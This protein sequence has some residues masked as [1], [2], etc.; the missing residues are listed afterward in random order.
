MG[1]QRMSKTTGSML[2]LRSSGG[3]LALLLP[4]RAL[5]TLVALAG[6]LLLAIGASVANGSYPLAMADLFAWMTSGV[7][8]GSRID[9]IIGQFR[10]PRA[11]AAALAGALLAVS[12]T[13][14]QAVTRNPLA[15]PSIV[16][17]SQGAGVAVLSLMVLWPDSPTG[18]VPVAAMV[19]GVGVAVV[20]LLLAGRG[21]HTIR[22]ILTGI[23][24]GAFLAAISSLLI[25]YGEL[26]LV[27]SALVWLAGSVHAAG[28]SDVAMLAVW[29]LLVLPVMLAASR[30]LN[31]LLLGEATATGL[32]VSVRRAQLVAIIAAVIAAAGAV[33]AVGTLGFVGLVAPHVARLMVGERQ[34]ILL[35]TSA[36]VGALLVASADLAGRLA[37]APVQVP[38]GILTALIGVPY[39]CA[40]LWKRRHTL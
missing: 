31:A 40:L 24:I 32:G 37:F 36:L 30:G 33:A 34:G 3:Q 18:L 14:L 19:G 9:L 22:F 26:Q 11:L 13:C 7:P 5:W 27:M 23:G 4:V 6:A 20:M 39:F 8:D 15:D 2:R 1:L 25:T 21:G 29:S 10:L 28:W 35:I 17:V 38:A 12:G 16:G